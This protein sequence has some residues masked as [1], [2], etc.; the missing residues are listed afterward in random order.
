MELPDVIKLLRS[1]KGLSQRELAK[2]FNVSPSTI[3]MY[4]TGQ[5]AP[6]TDTIQ[7][8]ADFFNVTTDYLLGRTDK[9]YPFTQDDPDDIQ[10]TPPERIRT[11]Q[12]KIGE[13]S[14][15]SLTFLEFQLERLRELD[16]EAVERRRAKRD[17]GRN[18][19]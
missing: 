13:L 6:D 15:E 3:A 9:E 12:K 5:R 16:L 7:I 2:I 8:F 10:P 4:E 17:A 1:N 14:P 19:K 11:F 18:K